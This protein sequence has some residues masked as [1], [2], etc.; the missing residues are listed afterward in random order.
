MGVSRPQGAQA[1]QLAG[2]SSGVIL[3]RFPAWDRKTLPAAV[4]ATVKELNERLAGAFVVITPRRVRIGRDP[5][6]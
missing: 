3:I 1:L 5:K 2:E 6:A 4:L